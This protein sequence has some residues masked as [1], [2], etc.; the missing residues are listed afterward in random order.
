[1]LPLKYYHNHK[2]NIEKKFVFYFLNART[3]YNVIT[4]M[5]VAFTKKLYTLKVLCHE[6]VCQLR[7]LN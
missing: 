6:I 2:S 1:M 4:K 5:H 7:P 3:K